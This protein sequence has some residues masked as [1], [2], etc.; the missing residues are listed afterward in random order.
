VGICGHWVKCLEQ[1]EKIKSGEINSCQF[2][3]ITDLPGTIVN[4][5]KISQ[6]GRLR[7]KIE[8]EGFNTQNNQGYH[9]KPKYSRQ[10][11]TASK[12]YY[13]CLQIG[14][15]INQLVE[16]SSDFKELFTSVQMTVRHSLKTVIGFMTFCE[17]DSE[18]LS[19]IGI[20]KK[21]IRF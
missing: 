6:T 19:V 11:L 20:T 5:A 14:H 18:Q 16:L 10:N 2:V 3:Q 15:L 13:Q 9:L 1:V 17:V 7:G 12:N 4:V 8:N 21:Q